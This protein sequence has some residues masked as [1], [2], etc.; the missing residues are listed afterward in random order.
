MT[1]VTTKEELEQALKN[2]EASILVKGELAAAMRKK[3]RR[4]KTAI[5][6]GAGLVLAGV[7]LIPFTGGAS[8]TASGIGLTVAAGGTTV[9]ATTAEVAIFAGVAALGLG[10]VSLALLKNYTFEITKQGHILLTSKGSK[11]S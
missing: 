1:T 11:Q 7:A 4:K 2:K 5:F 10:A 3:K 8:L 9:A 6:C